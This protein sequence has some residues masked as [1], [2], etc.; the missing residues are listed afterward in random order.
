MCGIALAGLGLAFGPDAGGAQTPMSGG[1]SMAPGTNGVGSPFELAFWQ[2]IAT[3]D[4]RMQYEAYLAQY[5]AGTFSGL[6]R[7]KIA[8]LDRAKGIVPAATAVSPVAPAPA[9]ANT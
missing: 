7:A 8:A 1:A 3:S 9:P 4:D 2:S 6:A 5:P